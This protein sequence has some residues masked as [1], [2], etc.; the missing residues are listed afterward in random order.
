MLDLDSAKKFK[1]QGREWTPEELNK[2]TLMQSDYS[3]KTQEIAKERKFH[4]NLKADLEHVKRDPNLAEA[5]KQAY[6]EKFHDYL[7]FVLA[8]A[9]AEAKA[10][11]TESNQPLQLPKELQD[12]MSQVDQFLSEVKTQKQSAIEAEIDSRFDVLSKKYPWADEDVVISKA[13]SLIDQ[14]KQLPPDQR[15]QFDD[16]TWENLWKSVHSASE[17]KAKKIYSEQIKQ[18]S[19]ANSKG[20]DAASSGGIPGQAPRTPKTIKEAGD[21]LRSELE[22]MG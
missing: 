3:R 10:Q 7:R 8:E 2:A 6:P 18:Q 15:V 21:L 12:K 13:Q 4:D 5:F 19:A 14:N 17:A 20:R 22:A 16:K 11:Q 9:K 1:F